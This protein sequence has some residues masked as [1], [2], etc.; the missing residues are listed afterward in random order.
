MNLRVIGRGLFQIH[1]G[2]PRLVVDIDRV[3]GVTRGF[4]ALGH[5]HGDCLADVIHFTVGQQRAQFSDR[6]L[7]QQRAQITNVIDREHGA[8][9]CHGTGL[10]GVHRFDC[11]AGIWAAH[12]Y[13][14]ELAHHLD[15]VDVAAVAVHQ[16]RIFLAANGAA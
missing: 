4:D 7:R 14:V 12:E 9:A 16:T 5:N 13:G 1:D 15:V 8:H 6:N 11:S 3:R 10:R 2:L